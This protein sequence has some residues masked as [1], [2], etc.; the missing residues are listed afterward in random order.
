MCAVVYKRARLLY[1]KIIMQLIL[2]SN[3]PRRREL[4]SKL[5]YPFD[6]VPATGEEIS[7]AVDPRD[8]VQELASRKATE[9]FASHG[10]CVVVG[11]DTVV[12]FDGRIL[13]KPKDRDDAIAMLCA[14]SGNV[15]F[16][17]TGVCVLSPVGVWL[18]C[19]STE[20]HFRKLSSD[21]IT[22]Y[23]DSGQAFGKAGAYGIQDDCHFVSSYKGDYDN[24]VGLPLYRLKQILQTIYN[25]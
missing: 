11:C 17:H 9:V 22:R 13:G 10:D 18:F 5:N 21:E 2:A 7:T 24:V 14:L 16:V 19:D 1:N 20:V 12:D 3:S 25:R 15:H 6:V 4:L 8:I 23:V